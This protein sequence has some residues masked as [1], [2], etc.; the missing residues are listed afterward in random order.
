MQRPHQTMRKRCFS[1]NSAGLRKPRS[2]AQ[3][4]E[5]QTRGA[6]KVFSVINSTTKAASSSKYTIQ[7]LT[8]VQLA[9]AGQVLVNLFLLPLENWM[10]FSGRG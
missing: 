10:H 5:E 7:M 3:G 2:L 6:T 4:K 8:L 1:K 9:K